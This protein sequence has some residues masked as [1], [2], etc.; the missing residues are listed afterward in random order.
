MPSILSSNYLKTKYNPAIIDQCLCINSLDND[1]KPNYKPAMN[2]D[3]EIPTKPNHS[4]HILVNKTF[5]KYKDALCESY[6]DVSDLDEAKDFIDDYVNHLNKGLILVASEELDL[7]EVVNLSSGVQN[8]IKLIIRYN[9]S[10]KK[11][12]AQYLDTIQQIKA[13]S[14]KKA[15]N[16]AYNHVENGQAILFAHVNS[17]FDLFEHLEMV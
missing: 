11:L 7:N 6:F 4:N 10:S 8:C 16:E 5:E 9:A 13:S 1:N 15:V 2:T 3:F 12:N 14:I 17:N